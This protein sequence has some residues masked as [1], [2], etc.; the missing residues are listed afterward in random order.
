[1]QYPESYKD[2]K[3]RDIQN[4]GKITEISGNDKHKIS[5]NLFGHFFV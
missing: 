5:L 4:P 3:Y 2:K 1:M